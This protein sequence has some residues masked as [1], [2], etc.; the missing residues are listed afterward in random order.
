[1]IKLYFFQHLI[2][3]KSRT[4]RKKSFRNQNRQLTKPLSFFPFSFIL[5]K[6]NSWLGNGLEKS[7]TTFK[8]KQ[9]VDMVTQTSNILGMM[10]DSSKSLFV[11]F[12]DFDMK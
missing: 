2:F 10:L 12:K 4:R 1:M 7:L 6:Q 5:R 8:S 11:H 3:E 9:V